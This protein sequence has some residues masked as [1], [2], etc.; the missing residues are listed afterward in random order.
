[1]NMRN[2]KLLIMMVRYFEMSVSDDDDGDEDGNG[3]G[4]GDSDGDEDGKRGW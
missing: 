4:D 2:R 1:M 3:D